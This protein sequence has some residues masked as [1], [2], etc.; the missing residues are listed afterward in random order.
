MFIRNITIYQLILFSSVKHVIK[1]VI[2]KL[3]FL[4][5]KD[6]VQQTQMQTHSLRRLTKA[7]ERLY[8]FMPHIVLT[9]YEHLFVAKIN[10]P[11]HLSI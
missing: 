9:M 4:V 7:D 10:L 1:T 11:I 6:V 5:T 2:Q 8:S 3:V